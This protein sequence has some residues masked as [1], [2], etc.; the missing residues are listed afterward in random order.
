[1]GLVVLGWAATVIAGYLLLFELSSTPGAGATAPARWPA[2]TRIAR[3]P[4]RPTLLLI[5]HP[6]CVCTRASLAEPARLITRVQGRVSTQVVFVKPTG[7]DPGWEKT[8]LWQRARALPDARVHLDAGS[9]EAARFGAATSGQTLL[10]GPDGQLWMSG[11]ITPRRS[12]EGDSL[13][14]QRIVALVTAGVAPP[15][16]SISAVYGCQLLDHSRTPR[17]EVSRLERLERWLGGAD[18]EQ[19]P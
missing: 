3:D 14:H 9:V 8:E 19:A 12:H 5:A 17:P 16:P 4:H 1:M 18:P 15:R 10:Y 7:L 11:G 2:D 6:H 13:G